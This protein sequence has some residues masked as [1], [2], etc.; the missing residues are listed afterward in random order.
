MKITEDTLEEV[1]DY[2][3]Q[4]FFENE[5]PTPDFGLLRSYHTLGL[6]THNYRSPKSKRLRG[7]KISISVYIDWE[8]K[9]LIE[10]MA[11]E[12]VHYYLEYKNIRPKKP[13]GKEFQEKAKE[14]NEKYGL[15]ISKKIDASNFKRL[16]GTPKFSWIMSHLLG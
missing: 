14:L 2:C 11:H 7:Q 3:N 1:F 5:L 10:I 9:D 12:M 13:H 8:R 6:F 16:S 4:S 15:H